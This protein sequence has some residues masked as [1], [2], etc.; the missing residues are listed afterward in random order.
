M[1][2]VEG[3]AQTARASLPFDLVERTGRF[4]ADVVRFA[5][6]V[7]VNPVTVPL[8]GQLVRAG[9]SVGANYCEADEAASKRDFHHK[10]GICRKEA[11]ETRHW[12]RMLVVAE[13]ALRDD[14]RALWQES[15]EFTLIFGAMARTRPRAK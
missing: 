3:P 9:T 5:K 11:K 14:A 2:K 12:L 4:G 15:K 1:P 13:P 7:P 8:I 6:R 10:I